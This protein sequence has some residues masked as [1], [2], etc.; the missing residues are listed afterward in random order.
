MADKKTMLEVFEQARAEIWNFQKK[1]GF[2]RDLT[3]HTSGEVPRVYSHNEN[4]EDMGNWSGSIL[5]MFLMFNCKEHANDSILRIFDQSGCRAAVYK[6][7]GKEYQRSSKGKDNSRT[8]LLEA[9][10]SLMG[11]EHGQRLQRAWKWVYMYSQRHPDLTREKLLAK[12]ITD[13]ST[14]IYTNL[15]DIAEYIMDKLGRKGDVDSYSAFK[16][17]IPKL[18]HVHEPPC[19]DVICS[20]TGCSRNN[21]EKKQLYWKA[22]AMYLQMVQKELA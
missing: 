20:L 18:L 13:P 4:Y 5:M 19:Y 22:S 7:W 3:H 1:I 2:P 10:L 12:A 8:N 6:D 17:I 16:C 15:D 11:P 9:I 14:D 21:R